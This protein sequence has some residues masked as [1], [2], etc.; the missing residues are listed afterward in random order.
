MGGNIGDER[1]AQR[2][3]IISPGVAPKGS[4]SVQVEDSA[5]CVTILKNVAHMFI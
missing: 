3:Y 2:C 1:S 5:S 4:T